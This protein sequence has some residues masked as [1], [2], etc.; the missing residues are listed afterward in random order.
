MTTDILVQDEQI[1]AG[2]EER[3]R[4]EPARPLE[5]PLHAPR[6]ARRALDDGRVDRRRWRRRRSLLT[7]ELERALPADAAR[8]AE[9]EAPLPR[10]IAP[11]ASAR[12]DVDRVGGEVLRRADCLDVVRSADQTLAGEEP[13]GKR[14]VLPGG[15]HGHGERLAV[16]PD[17]ERLL[18]GELVAVRAALVASYALDVR[19][20]HVPVECSL[21][22]HMI[23]HRRAAGDHPARR[24]L[25]SL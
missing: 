17:L 10:R 6:L 14:L 5:R 11:Q 4:V 22:G 23:R 2:V 20:G 7:N 8:R 18:D 3:G 16:D 25:A 15:A 13:R 19:A 24:A 9:I 12:P 21:H 1:S